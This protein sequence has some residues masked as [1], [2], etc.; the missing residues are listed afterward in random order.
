MSL[1]NFL[2][3]RKLLKKEIPAKYHRQLKQKSIQKEKTMKLTKT[4]AFCLR[5]HTRFKK[6]ECMI[7]N[8]KELFFYCSECIGL[9]RVES[10]Q[11]FYYVPEKSTVKRKV[12]F[13]W[14]G[15]LTKGQAY[16]SKR[17]VKYYRQKKPHL[18]HAVTGAGKTEMLFNLLDHALKK[19]HRVAVAS[20]R[21][22]VCLELFPRFQEVF[23]NEKI[24]L[25]YGNS[26]KEYEYTKFVVTT[27]HQLLRFYKAFDL[28]VVD[29]V[30]AFPYADNPVL[31]FGTKNALKKTGQLVYLT[32]TPS[33][34]LM[35]QINQKKLV[36]SQ[37]SKRYHGYQLPVPTCHFNYFLSRSLEKGELP[38]FFTN[39]LE[40][41]NRQCLIFFPNIDRMKVCYELLKQKYPD[42]KITYVYANE[43]YREEKIKKMRRQEIDWLLT[44]TILERGVTFPNIDVIV[45]ESHHRVFNA[46]SLV[47]ISGRVGRKEEYPT[48]S[49]Y[50]LHSGKT[51]AMRQ[52]IEQIKEMNHRGG[53]K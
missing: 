45:Y 30:D 33:E 1:D 6:E 51:K 16:I 18:I 49:I 29:E 37:L 26:D 3:G 36:Y 44:T 12:D 4:E 10:R 2:R 23:P 9:G 24:A 5:C 31:E 15:E 39:V 48:G 28:I 41:Q 34:K 50:F 53:F 47:Q 13:A 52:A 17:L 22:D 27:T 21:V 35:N 38:N 42:K 25:L 43:P 20:P 40:K 32:A 46:A 19:G 7:E 11:F 8:K 14:Q